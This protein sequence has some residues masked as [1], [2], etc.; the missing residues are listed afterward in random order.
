MLL[1]A[2]LKPLTSQVAAAALFFQQIRARGATR[3]RQSGEPRW[4]RKRRRADS[5]FLLSSVRRSLL[6]LCDIPVLSLGTELTEQCWTRSATGG[7]G[8]TDP[9]A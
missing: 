4:H 8:Y 6:A 7:G 5:A 1:V 9:G 2:S 3:Q